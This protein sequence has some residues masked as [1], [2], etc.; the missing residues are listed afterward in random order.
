MDHAIALDAHRDDETVIFAQV[1]VEWFRYLH[2]PHI[3]I[4][5]VDDLRGSVG[6]LRIH[7]TIVLLHMEVERL[8]RQFR[9]ELT[10]FPVE[11]RTVV[12]KDP[13][14][15]IRRLLHLSQKDSAADGMHTAGRQIEHV[16]R[17]H[18]VIGQHLGDGTIRHPLLVFI[19]RNLLFETRIE[20]GTLLGLDDIPHL[21]LAHLPVLTHRHLIVGMHLDT[22]VLL[23]IDKLHQQ[24]QLAVIFPVHRLAQDRLGHLFEH[25]AQVQTFPETI[26][27]HAHTGGHGTHLPALPYRFVG[28]CH[29]LIRPELRSAPHDGVQVRFK[30]H[31]IQQR[32]FV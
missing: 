31:R 13:V 4:R 6:R 3:E 1:A 21:R 32:L 12:V 16:A 18:L 11:P 30:Q 2:H 28:R 8:S 14:G 24:G 9:M 19:G 25:K 7:G 5:G 17:L 20:V 23:G 29:S 27:H 10:R 15:H 26:T 22:Q